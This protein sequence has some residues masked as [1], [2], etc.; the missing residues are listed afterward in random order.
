MGRVDGKVAFITGGARGQGRAH[1]IRLAE[2]GAD[3]VAVD[4]CADVGSSPAPPAT[5]AELKET[6]EAVKSLGRKAVGVVAD[7]RDQVALDEAVARGVDELGPIDIAVINHGIA[8]FG[9]AWELDDQ[10]W[11][12]ML[13]INLTG[14][15]RAVKAVVPP[16]IAAERGGSIIVTASVA[17]TVG[18]RFM[19]HYSAA[20]HGVVGLMRSLAKELGPTSIRVNAVLPGSVDSPM[21]NSEPVQRLFDPSDPATAPLRES[22][23]SKRALPVEQLDPREISHAVLW[24]ASDEARYVTGVP[25]PVDAGTIVQ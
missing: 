2:E 10:A 18:M 6:V 19:A 22:F 14:V 21:V 1:A 11:Q 4:L 7:V 15:W 17:G 25:L 8:S 23:Q 20:K 16:M 9:R 5:H 13:D 12:D 24:L 3:I